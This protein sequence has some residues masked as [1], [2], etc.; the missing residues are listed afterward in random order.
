ML[1]W[2]DREGRRG[3]VGREEVGVCLT[4]GTGRGEGAGLEGRR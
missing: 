3:G 4:G 1:D 2:R